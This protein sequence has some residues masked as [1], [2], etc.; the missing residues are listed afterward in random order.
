MKKIPRII[1]NFNDRCLN[2]CSFCFI[3]FDKKGAGDLILWQEIVDRT[4][5]FS[6]DMLSFSGCDP[7][8]YT[9]FYKLLESAKK[10]CF[11]GVDTSLIWLDRDGFLSCYQKLDQ[12][13]TSWDDVPQMPTIQRYDT[14]K[15]TQFM[16]NLAFVQ[17]YI[18]NAVIHTLYSKRN[19]AYLTHIADMLLA[20]N[21]STWSLYQF[22]PFVFHNDPQD[23]LC[24]EQEF[25][26]KGKALSRY[27]D[28]RMDFEYV[29]CQNR[30]N[31]YFFVS[32]TGAAYTTLPGKIGKYQPLGSIFDKDIFEKWRTY[33]NPDNA[34][35]I[36]RKKI[37]REV[38]ISKNERND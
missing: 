7:F 22:W 2:G 12:L 3:P 36:L 23:F 30:A 16:D 13:S 31:G 8:Y 24:D 33:S 29:P 25:L 37:K 9:E 21:I 38:C 26:A 1:F 28:G 35:E 4:A 5:D 27:I 11:W 17:Q 18:P 32:S 20:R 34:E 10:D 14:Q 15:M 19:S 6:P